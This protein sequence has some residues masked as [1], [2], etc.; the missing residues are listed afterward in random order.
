[1]GVKPC[2]LVNYTN[3]GSLQLCMQMNIN[4][5]N[6]NDI[7]DGGSHKDAGGVE[8]VR[9]STNET[10][11]HMPS[12]QGTMSALI[13]NS[14]IMLHYYILIPIVSTPQVIIPS[15]DNIYTGDILYERIGSN[16]WLTRFIIYQN[17]KVFLQVS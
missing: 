17:V 2:L 3:Q 15:P 1:M 13:D 14:V 7:L 5:I 8:D 11:R 4:K 9:D 16:K 6:I 12:T 10:T